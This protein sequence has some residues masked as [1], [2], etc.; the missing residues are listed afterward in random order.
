MF[1][2]RIASKLG[3]VEDDYQEEDIDDESVLSS[4]DSRGCQLTLQPCSAQLLQQV[5]DNSCAAQEMARGL[6]RHSARVGRPRAS[7]PQPA[8]RLQLGALEISSPSWRPFVDAVATHSGGNPPLKVRRMG[9]WFAGS[10]PR[11][12]AGST[13]KCSNNSGAIL[14]EQRSTSLPP[15]NQHSAL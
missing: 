7:V 2:W 4:G 3:P 9:P 1:L 8:P 10:S 6:R 5:A 14:G 11:K 12:M 13:H 15:G